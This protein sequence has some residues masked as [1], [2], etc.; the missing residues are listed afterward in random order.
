M[1]SKAFCN[2]TIHK[3]TVKWT[4]VVAPQTMNDVSIIILMLN[5][6]IH[7]SDFLVLHNRIDVLQITNDKSN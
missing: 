5:T 2:I 4:M 1:I 7:T 3:T 6:N